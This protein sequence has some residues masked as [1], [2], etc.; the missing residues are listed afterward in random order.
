MKFIP[1]DKPGGK[2]GPPL[3]VKEDKKTETVTLAIRKSGSD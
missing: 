1:P 3:F 2:N